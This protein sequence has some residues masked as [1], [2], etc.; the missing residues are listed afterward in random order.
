MRRI[1]VIILPPSLWIGLTILG[2]GAQSLSNLVE[3]GI[4]T[5]VSLILGLRTTKK[6]AWFLL[7]IGLVM[8]FLFRSLMPVIPE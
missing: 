1:V 5:F 6:N 8:A 2:V 4:V 7:I 3:L